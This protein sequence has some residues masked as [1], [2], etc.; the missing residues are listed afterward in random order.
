[1]D[2]ISDQIKPERRKRKA[3]L[4]LLYALLGKLGQLLYEKLVGFGSFFL[5]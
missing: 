5:C 3:L 1:M 2:K 4:D